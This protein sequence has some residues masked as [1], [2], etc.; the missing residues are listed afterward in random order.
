MMKYN[1]EVIKEAFR[2]DSL[3]SSSED[4]IS[5]MLR[6]QNSNLNSSH[7]GFNSSTGKRFH[8]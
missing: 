3:A 1:A 4:M 2:E 7:K 5:G 8:H 6:T